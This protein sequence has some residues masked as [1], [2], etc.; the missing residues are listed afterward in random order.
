MLAKRGRSGFVLLLTLL[1]LGALF[2]YG[3][4]LVRLQVADKRFAQ[5]RENALV[6]EQAA[7]AGLDEALLQL[8]REVS[9]KAGLPETR[10]PHSGATY[11]VTF[12]RAQT[13]VPFSTNNSASTTEVTGWGGRRVP[14]G[15][16][17]LV[18]RGSFGGSTALDEGM[19]QTS[20]SAFRAALI[21]ADKISLSGSI[22]IDAWNSNLGPYAQSVMPSGADLL[23]NSAAPRAVEMSNVTVQGLITVGPG[24]SQDSTLY[25]TGK[26]VY[27]GFK[28]ATSVQEL[29]VT[30]P[31]VIGPSQGAIT[32]GSGATRVLTPGT[33]SSFSASKGILELTPGDYVVTGSV[34]LGS[35]GYLQVPKGPVRLFLLGSAS[36]SSGGGF[37]NPTLKPANMLI[38]GGSSPQVLDLQG[39]SGSM[40]NFGINA[41]QA[42]LRFGG[43]NEFYG[44]FVAREVYV[45]GNARF[46]FDTALR[47]TPNTPAAPAAPVLKVRW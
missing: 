46:H 9:W 14:A 43:G 40:L 32:V 45:N 24:G 39:L 19:V 4:A 8:T 22:L 10:L 7:R 34:T 5:R 35:G 36:V 21:G 18:S 33:Y 41:P 28:V 47:Y 42:I 16:I 29:A 23:T 30:P 25:V 38:F 26:P 11:T 37:M 17:H 2:F 1:V 3:L 13:A 12:D 6:A 27:Q 44:S 15:F 20:S 31:P